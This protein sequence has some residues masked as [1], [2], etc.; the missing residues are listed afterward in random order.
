MIVGL[1]IYFLF[2]EKVVDQ[3]VGVIETEKLQEFIAKLA[4]D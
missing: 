3:F 4:S 1:N 2:L